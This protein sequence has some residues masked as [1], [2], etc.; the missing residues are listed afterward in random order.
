MSHFFALFLTIVLCETGFSQ[1]SSVN[2]NYEGKDFTRL[3]HAWKAQ[4]ITHPTES[5]LY[6]KFYLFRALQKTG[7]AN[8]YLG[9]LTGNF[10]W[11]GKTY[12]LKAGENNIMFN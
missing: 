3:K 1:E 7:M 11:N 9:M 12:K 5:T 8:S 2:I 4:W 10:I 6:F